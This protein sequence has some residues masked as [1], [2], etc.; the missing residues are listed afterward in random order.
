MHIFDQYAGSRSVLEWQSRRGHSAGTRRRL[1][2]SAMLHGVG[3][4]STLWHW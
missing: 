1:G 3:S 2:S 4:R